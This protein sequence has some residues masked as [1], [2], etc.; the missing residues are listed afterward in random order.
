MPFH[1]V[2]ILGGCSSENTSVTGNNRKLKNKI[3]FIVHR[4]MS[5]SEPVES[6]GAES[7]S[8]QLTVFCI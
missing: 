8:Y 2:D 1:G 6:I 3:K 4:P 5:E 7:H